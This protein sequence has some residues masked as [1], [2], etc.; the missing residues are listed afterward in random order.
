MPSVQILDTT[1]REGE[2]FDIFPPATRL[3][4]ATLL[5]RI[6]VGRVE[7]TV[8]YPPRTNRGDLEPIIGALKQSGT[9]V[10][11]HGRACREDVERIS[12]YD[13]EG[14]GLYIAVSSL[15][16]ENKL[17][18]ISEEVSLQRLCDSVEHAKDKGIPYIR[19]TLEDASRLHIEDAVSGAEKIV[20]ATK[21]LKD[22]GATMVSVPDTSGLMAPR[23]AREFFARLRELSALPL[24]AHFHND[25]GLASANTIEAA[26]E[27]AAELQVTMQGIGDRNGI[28]DLYEVV[29]VLEDVHGFRTGVDRRRLKEAY[30]AF[31]RTTGL[32]LPWRH[33]LSEE[34]Q[35]VRAGVHQSMT[36]KRPDGYI[37]AKKLAND[38]DGPAYAINQYLSHNLIHDLL[39]E[40]K[41]GLERDSSR[42][43]T[44]ILAVSARNGNASISRIQETI[45]R[46]VGVEVPRSRLAS[47]L[48]G[49]RV[50]VL[51]RL[52]PQYPAQ[53]IAA[54]VRRW[55][56]VEAVDEVYGEADM[57]VTMRLTDGDKPLNALRG[58]F[59]GQIQEMRVLLA[60]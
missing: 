27:G 51:L 4:V 7:L 24:S 19:A 54:E 13:V 60:D 50:Y 20:N 56:E 59:T 23:T 49:Q 55:D 31:A 40:Y 32:R 17:H 53:T 35:T 25:Y 37:P 47:L 10:V 3:E 15:H 38:F 28:A 46:E 57:I 21:L 30:S 42:R 11:L 18:G 33:P 12:N 48:G 29:A 14:C 52:R 2:L 6:R 39:S 45:K 8:D 1:L 36:I 5:S 44:E 34:A 26:L 16:R 43:V 22:A 58:K 9:E 41:P